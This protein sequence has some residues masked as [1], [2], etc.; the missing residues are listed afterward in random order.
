M[1][2]VKRMPVRTGN[3]DTSAGMQQLLCGLANC[4]LV[5]DVLEMIATPHRAAYVPM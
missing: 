3:N 2:S 1:V 5:F 4:L